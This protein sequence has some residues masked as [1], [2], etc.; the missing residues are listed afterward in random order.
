MDKDKI[1]SLID[2]AMLDENALFG[3]EKAIKENCIG[4]K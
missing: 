1:I 2:K 4:Y 3:L